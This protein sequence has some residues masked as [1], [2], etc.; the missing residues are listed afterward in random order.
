M[1]TTKMQQPSQAAHPMLI[2]IPQPPSS[3]PDTPSDMPGTPTSTTTSLS[4]LSTTAIK[5]GH[6]GHTQ[7]NGPHRGHQSQA[8]TNSLEAERADRISRLAG[9]S[10]LTALRGGSQPNAQTTASS[11]FGQNATAAPAY[12]DANGQPVASTKMS[13]VGTAS[14]T[15]SGDGRTL[16]GG[17]REMMDD[18]EDEDLRSMDTNFR[19]NDSASVGGGI[20]NIGGGG[21]RSAMGGGGARSEAL[22]PMDED[23]ATRSVGGFDDRMSD[24]GN[25]SLVGF[26]E[27]AGST[28][29]GPI[30]QRRPVPGTSSAGAMA[31]ARWQLERSS[32]GISDTSA[33]GGV[34]GSTTATAGSGSTST[35]PAAR[36][37]T[38]R[39]VALPDTAVSDMPLAASAAQERRDARMV[40]GVATD[41]AAKMDVAPGDDDVFVDT[42]TRN[43]LP[44]SQLQQHGDLAHRQQNS[45]QTNQPTSPTSREATE[46]I[47]QRLDEDES[48]VGSSGPVLGSAGTSGD[49][50]GQFYFEK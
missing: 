46:R 9:L 19:T 42:S 21:S 25:A 15:S 16:D 18:V 10:N 39:Q 48:R 47:F 50:L 2:N 33:A 34:A 40:D 36:R 20:S 29:S 35:A 45:Q 23:L 28:V 4:A 14:A 1:E 6:R 38:V 22:D 43:P 26:G 30:Y 5:D 13:T 24:D 31:F 8:S 17:D 3:N 44:I 49:R 41:G 12:F 37:D 27:G 32:S 11:N 7:H